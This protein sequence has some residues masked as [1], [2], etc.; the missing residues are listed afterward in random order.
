MSGKRLLAARI[1]G[2]LV[3]AAMFGTPSFAIS[4]KEAVA[5]AVDSNPEIGQAVENREAVEFEL[6]QARGLFLPSID[7]EASAGAQHLDNATRRLGGLDDDP[8]YPSEVGLTLTQKL[9]DGGA[10]RAELA[11]QASRVDSAS[12]RVLERS[13]DI[14]LQVV[15]QYLE[16]MLQQ[17]IVGE[18]RRNEAFHRGIID[19]LGSLIDGGILTAADRQQALERLQNAKAREKQAEEDLHTAAASFIKLVGKPLS[20]PVLPKSVA[21]ALPG[22]LDQAIGIART[23]NPRIHVARADIGA[24]DAMVDAARAKMLPEVALEAR[25]AVGNDISG[26]EDN[27]TDLGVRVVARWNLYRGGI[28]VANEQEQIRRAS[29]QRLVLHQMAR[30]VE[31]AVRIS[32]ERRI[33]QQEL[34][35]T[36]RRQAEMNSQLVNSYR[37]QLVVGQRSLLDVLGAQDSRFN[38]DI[39]SMT[40]QY[41]SLFAEYRLLAATGQLLKTLGIPSPQQSEA[42]ARQ[43][44]NVPPPPPTETFARVPSRQTNDLPFDL[45]SP[46]RK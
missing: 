37:Q 21:Y 30:E 15:R 45:L 23:N 14:A 38:V 25:G 32:W 39:L 13:E 19:D 10:R 6:R 40:A 18:T 34:A 29:E 5:T 42:Y 22:T 2:G 26:L 31:E 33:R 35:V 20:N 36:L 46:I 7:L 1:A 28:D 44:F 17:R 9:Y 43:E 4:L 3:A 27:T 11:R 41:A 12:F 8:L 16:Y 24:A